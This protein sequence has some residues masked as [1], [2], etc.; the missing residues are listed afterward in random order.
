MLVDLAR[1]FIDLPGMFLAFAQKKLDGLCQSFMAFSQ[2]IQ[3]LID[4]HMSIV[5]GKESSIGEKIKPTHCAVWRAENEPVGRR[6]EP[7][8]TL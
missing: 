7:A 2:S 3:A 4:G 6:W 8:E 5:R 1:M